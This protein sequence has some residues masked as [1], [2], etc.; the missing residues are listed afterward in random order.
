MPIFV[1]PAHLFNPDPV[2][3]DVVPRVIS[4]GTALNGE[5]DVIQTDG[6]G[7]WEI[8]YGEMDVDS[9]YLQRVWDAW[10]SHLSGGAQTVL[11]PLLSLGTAP[12]PVA[13]NGIADP[14]DFVAD[15]DY[16]P[17]E[18]RYA[19]PHIS[20]TVSAS[21]ALRATTLQLTVSQGAEIQPGMKFSVD[22]RG[23]K[24]ERVLSRSRMTATCKV[25]PP[26]RE[27]I[28]AGTSAD[29][30]WPVVRCRAAIGQDLSAAISL[31]M[32]GTTSISFVEDP[33]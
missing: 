9:P 21:A 11:V 24:V 20:A 29:F 8:S 23:F 26:A 31:G 2:K 15:D 3:A 4:G 25:A 12:R 28:P 18:V 27:A 5:E 1:F 7:R 13:G 30:E 6:G 14:S 33:N 19:A 22:G 17:T 32:F 10:T 16:F